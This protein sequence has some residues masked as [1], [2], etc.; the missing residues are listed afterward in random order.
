MRIVM[1]L[2]LIAYLTSLSGCTVAVGGAKVTQE[3]VFVEPGAVCRIATDDKI[4]IATVADDGTQVV[5][6]KNIAGMYVL[7]ASV[8]KEM[9]AEWLKSH[10][11]K[12]QL[13]PAPKAKTTTMSSIAEKVKPLQAIAMDAGN[14]RDENKDHEEWLRRKEAGSGIAD[15]A[16]AEK[17]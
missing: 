3:T 9:R 15:L 13:V 10:P 2:I 14:I 12:E 8:Y 17:E 5:V 16:P 4:K 6:E 11:Q 7:P 1:A